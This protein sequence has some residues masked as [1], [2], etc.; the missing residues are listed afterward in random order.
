[1]AYVEEVVGVAIKV[2]GALV[3]CILKKPRYEQ[4]SVW[5]NGHTDGRT[6]HLVDKPNFGS[7]ILMI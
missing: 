7:L 6:S 3:A 4:E 1:M 5:R 2:Y